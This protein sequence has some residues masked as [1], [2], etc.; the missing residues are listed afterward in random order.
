[1]KA[2]FTGFLRRHRRWLA[3]LAIPPIL[4]L[5][6]AALIA[7]TGLAETAHPTRVAVILGTAVPGG[8]PSIRLQARLDRAVELY[9][10][11]YYTEV[12][13]SGGTGAE[14]F[15]EAM[16]MKNYLVERGVPAD[17]IYADSN[18]VDTYATA[19]FTAAWLKEHNQ[20]EILVISQF[21]HLPRTEMTLQ[22]FGVPTVYATYPQFFEPRDYRS[23]ARE[24]FAYAWYWIR[25]Y[26]AIP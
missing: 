19:R 10:S 8:K 15:D 23:L 22:R 25:P 18:G 26:P 2:A 20:T 7:R 24:V 17:Q 3:L 13:V 4:F 9:H 12:I 6:A 16:V 14:G 21:F 5:L 11:G 1:M